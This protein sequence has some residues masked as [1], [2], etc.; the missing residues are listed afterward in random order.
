MVSSV[1]KSEA[2]QAHPQPN[3]A[4]PSSTSSHHS[5]S[6]S[7]STQQAPLHKPPV[8]VPAP[9]PQVNVWQ[10]RKSTLKDVDTN[11]TAA[12]TTTTTDGDGKLRFTFKRKRTK[13]L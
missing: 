5:N 13:M 12:T 1:A 10:A 7:S 2:K 6:S 9:T 4:M 11:P 8:T 3:A